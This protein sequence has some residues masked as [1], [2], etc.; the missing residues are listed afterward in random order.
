MKYLE[1]IEG[2]KET[3]LKMG[4]GFFGAAD[5]S[6]FSQIPDVIYPAIYCNAQSI[7]ETDNTLSLNINIYYIK[8]VNDNRDNYIINQSDAVDFLT[9]LIERFC[10]EYDGETGE[11]RTFNFFVDKFA[12]VCNG[13]YLNVDLIVGKDGTC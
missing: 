12:D 4:A 10:E 13:A 6:E 5:I 8:Q 9:D 3:S 1:I 2:L 7:T 11:E